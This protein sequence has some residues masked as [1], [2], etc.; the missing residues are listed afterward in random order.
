MYI[1]DPNPWDDE[2]TQRDMPLLYNIEHDPSEKYNIVK[3]NLEVV[4]KLLNLSDEHIRSVP[5]S[6]S[7]YDAILPSYKSAYDDYNKKL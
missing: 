7:Q 5:K 2:L 3:E 4:Q 6:P 1:K